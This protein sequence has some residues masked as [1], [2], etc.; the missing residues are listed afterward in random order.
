MV[1]GVSPLIEWL[2]RFRYDPQVSGD[3]DF[4]PAPGGVNASP[5]ASLVLS[6]GE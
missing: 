1:T 4:V 2:Q 3:P 5:S 6:V